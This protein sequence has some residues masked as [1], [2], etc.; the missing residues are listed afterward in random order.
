[1]EVPLGHM[2]VYHNIEKM[3]RLLVE[4]EACRVFTNKPVK[5]LIG[6]TVW[7]FTGT[8]WPRKYSRASVF[9][10]E[11]VGETGKSGFRNFVAGPGHCSQP[12]LALND[13]D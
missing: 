7:T 6:K 4:D 2:V 13:L 1:M 3:G 12:P 9:E 10:I 8:G 5:D 11:K